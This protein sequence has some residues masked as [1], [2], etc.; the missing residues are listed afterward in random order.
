MDEADA[1]EEDVLGEA[2]KVCGERR[3][4]EGLL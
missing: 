2:E 4:W 3:I 1:A